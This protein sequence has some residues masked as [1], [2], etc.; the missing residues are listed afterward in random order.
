MTRGALGVMVRASRRCV[1]ASDRTVRCSG[2]ASATASVPVPGFSN[3]RTIVSGEDTLCALSTFGA[4]SCVGSN[5]LGELGVSS[6]RV[7]RSDVPVQVPLP[8]PAL[9]IAASSMETCAVLADGSLSCWGIHPDGELAIPAKDV[10]DGPLRVPIPAVVTSVALD[11]LTGCA[12]DAAGDVW[13]WGRGAD[14][15]LGDGASTAPRGPGRV[16][17]VHN[18]R[19][20]AVG[21][22]HACAV[23][24]DGTV[25][26]WGSNEL[27]QLGDGHEARSGPQLATRVG[28]E[29]AVHI[30][31]AGFRT[32][33]LLEDGSVACWGQGG[34]GE[35]GDTEATTL[36]PFHVRGL[37]SAQSIALG[38]E[39]T[40]AVR[41]PAGE[42][43][44]WGKLPAGDVY[45]PA[46][47][48]W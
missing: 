30:V 20:V 13:C 45:V 19:E 48:S 39:T 2:W 28:I 11:I 4:V 12:V 25:R 27:A 15:E 24:A 23:L 3:V 34:H 26:C 22:E 33:A 35:N 14:G 17:G 32:C 1:V 29:G 44:C 38:A 7:Q 46:S 41:E 6:D 16:V 37:S 10:P 31:A 21:L 40:C 18:A 36:L 5:G 42:V 8:S 9:R 47:M 43:F